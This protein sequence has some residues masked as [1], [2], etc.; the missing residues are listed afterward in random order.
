MLKL[1]KDVYNYFTTPFIHSDALHRL[2][3]LNKAL[4]ANTREESEFWL[5]RLD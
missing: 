3:L 1:F 2:E 5:S 4:G